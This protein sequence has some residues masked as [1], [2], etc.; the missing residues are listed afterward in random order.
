[1]PCRQSNVLGLIPAR[2][3]SK[4]IPRKNIAPMA[5]KPLLAYTTEA[6]RSTDRLTRVILST[7]DE[8]IATA[9]LGLGVE[10]PF[11]RPVE[12]ARDSS[13]SLCLCVHA[14]EWL[15]ANE[16]YEADILV[17]LQPTCPLRTAADIDA[18]IDMLVASGG[19]SVVSVAEVPHKFNPGW[20]FRV[21]DAELVRYTAEP[22]S[23]LATRRQ[24]MDRTYYRNGAVYATRAETVLERA[25]L[26]G[27]KCLAYIMPPERS[28]NIDSPADLLEAELYLSGSCQG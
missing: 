28:F 21:R 1:M 11:K 17:L 9:G 10:V 18:C 16:G 3:G 7:D 2:G 12:L 22:L 19:D 25:S 20:Q 26:Y 15:A 8:K 24:D 4:G 27:D 6:A 23:G 13:T 14:L 5:G